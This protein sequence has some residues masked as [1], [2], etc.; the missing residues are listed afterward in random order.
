LISINSLAENTWAVAEASS[1]SANKW[2]T[3][4]TDAAVEG[5]WVWSNGDAWS[6]TN[7]HSG[8]PNNVG[9]FGEDCMQLG[10]FGDETWNDEPCSS[11]FRYVCE[12]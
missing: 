9:T 1:R 10:R 12:Q 2:W 4:G 11:P 7:W 6:Y 5:T 3:G 8:E